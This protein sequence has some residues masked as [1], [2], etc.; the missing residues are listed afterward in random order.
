M[1][2]IIFLAFGLICA[3]SAFAEKIVCNYTLTYKLYNE[4]RRQK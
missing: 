1:K 2:R 3:A 4:L